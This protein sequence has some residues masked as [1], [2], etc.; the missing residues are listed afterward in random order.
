MQHSTNLVEFLN[1][2]Y[3]IKERKRLLTRSRSKLI[4]YFK[5]RSK[6]KRASKESNQWLYIRI[7]VNGTAASD[8]ST[9]ISLTPEIWDAKR[10]RIKGNSSK[11]SEQNRAIAQIENDLITLFNDLRQNGVIPTA[12]MIKDLY[13]CSGLRSHADLGLLTYYNRFLDFHKSTVSKDTFRCYK[14]RLNYLTRYLKETLQLKVTIDQINPK[15]ILAYH[16]FITQNNAGLN[17]ARRAVQTISMVLDFAVIQDDLE[18]NP[19][20]SLSLPRSKP[21]PIKY[22]TVKEIAMLQNCPYFD[23]RLQKVTDCF[24]FQCFTG[25]AYNELMSFDKAKHIRLDDENQQWIMIHRSKTGTLSTIPIIHQAQE[26][27]E[28]YDY[29]LPIITNQK[30]N[31]YIKEAAKI[32]GIENPEEIT[33][34]VGRKTA[35]TFLLNQ[36]V[37]LETVSKVLGHKSLKITQMYY[38][39]LLTET[40]KSNFKK[41]GLL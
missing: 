25:M 13:R 14:S 40:I 39:E 16:R 35:G 33:T 6:K 3:T 21:N 27:L 38:A 34:H 31:D 37:P 26:L 20:K 29:K 22:L 17:H 10:Q 24:L 18:N 8:M 32:A 19:L 5:L 1:S 36:G 2:N 12:S 9:G 30:L 41:S 4:I 7:K 11:I 28:K 23:S 15:W